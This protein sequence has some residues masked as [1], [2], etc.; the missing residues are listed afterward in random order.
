MSTR[1]YRQFLGDVA[2]AS[3]PDGPGDDSPVTE[4]EIADLDEPV[5]RYLRF[6]GVVGRPRVWSFEG[7]FAGRFRQRVD[8]PWMDAVAFQYN[9]R[10]DVAR[11]FTM[12]LRAAKVVPMIGHDTY[13]RGSGRM[14]GK[15]FGLFTVADGSG[16][17]FDIGELTTYLNDAILLAPSMVLGPD[18][19]WTGT[20]ENSFEV[21]L[22]DRGRQVTAQVS[23]D[24]RGAP[25]DFS[26]FDRWAALPGGPVRA[27]WHTPVPQWSTVE[28]RPFPGPAEVTWDLDDGPFTYIRGGF[29]PGSVRYDVAPPQE[30]SARV[31]GRLPADDR[32]DVLTGLRGAGIMAAEL[33]MPSGGPGGHD[34]GR[35]PLGRLAATRR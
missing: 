28:G 29:V 20:G 14:L 34:G 7:R 19:S 5:Q 2:A 18:T 17:E 11:I 31:E 23:L 6:M 15:V 13:V 9:T 16:K 1:L 8:G 33:V 26:T 22:T 30:A 24:D 25:I 32:H 3:L 35:G 12:R 4:E 27:R 10:L 21:R